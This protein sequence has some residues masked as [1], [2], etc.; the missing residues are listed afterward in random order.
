MNWCQVFF[1]PVFLGALRVSTIKQMLKKEPASLGCPMYEVQWLLK[2]SNSNRKPRDNRG[3]HY[4]FD[5]NGRKIL[6]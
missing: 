2:L 4:V 3:R 6:L 1:V 5:T